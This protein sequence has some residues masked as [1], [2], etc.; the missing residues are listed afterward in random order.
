MYNVKNIPIS[1]RLLPK[2]NT[3]PVVIPSP[4]CWGANGE[5]KKDDGDS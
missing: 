4:D 5:E 3:F 2:C 1:R